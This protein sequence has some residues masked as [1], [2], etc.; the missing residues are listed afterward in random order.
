MSERNRR[1]GRRGTNKPV[2]CINHVERLHSGVKTV[3]VQLNLIT[4]TRSSDGTS[5]LVL[6][7]HRPSIC[8]GKAQPNGTTLVRRHIC[9]ETLCEPKTNHCM[10]VVKLKTAT[11]KDSDGNDCI[12]SV[13]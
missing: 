2:L 4:N 13:L 6:Q 12:S 10:P 3:T 9:G 1:N 8:I 5:A 11:H 7:K